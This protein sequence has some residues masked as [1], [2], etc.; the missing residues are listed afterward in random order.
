MII[1]L[2]LVL[3]VTAGGTLASYLYDEGAAFAARLCAGAC[4]GIAALGLIGF[5]WASFLGLTPFAILLTV[6][7]IMLLPLVAL[8][9]PARRSFIQQDLLVNYR[10][11]RAGLK[12]PSRLPLGYVAFYTIA[13]LILWRAFDRAMIETPEGIFTGVLNNFGD[14][15]F[16]LSVITSF[17]FGNNYPPED[18]TYAGVRFTYPFLTD[19]VSAIFVRCGADLRQSMFIAN[20]VVAL[21]FVGLLHRWSLEMLRDK[22]AATLTPLLVLL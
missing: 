11:I 20:F 4:I 8:N 6:A 17:A 10:A 14:L 9:K 3:L 21:S 13:A 7:V 19:F 15:P 12:H 16:H 18:P 22:L 1:S 5:V 2:V